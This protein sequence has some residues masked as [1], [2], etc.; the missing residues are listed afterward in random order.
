MVGSSHDSTHRSRGPT[1]R[2]PMGCNP[3]NTCLQLIRQK[4]PPKRFM[5]LF[6]STYGL[7]VVSKVVSDRFRFV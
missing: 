3:K 4:D 7:K 2:F 6:V 1:Q 5:M